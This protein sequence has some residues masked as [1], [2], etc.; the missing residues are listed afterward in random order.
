MSCGPFS[1]TNAAETASGLVDDGGMPTITV[2]TCT[3]ASPEAVARVLMDSSLA[4]AWTSGLDRLEVVSGTPGEVGCVG[5]AHYRQQT[6]AAVF[7]DVLTDVVPNRYYASTVTGGDI[8]AQ[9]QT[10]LQPTQS[11]E[12]EI[13][14]RWDGSGT[15]LVTRLLLPFLRRRIRRRAEADLASLRRLAESVD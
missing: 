7:T 8:S 10:W 11:G 6:G 9:V 4:P 15:S 5:K 2:S 14:I 13:R 3:T 12:T 1:E